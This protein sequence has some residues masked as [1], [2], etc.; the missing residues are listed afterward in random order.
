MPQ[1]KKK[2][3]TKTTKKAVA[4]KVHKKACCRTAC[5]KSKG[6]TTGEKLHLYVVTAL[7]IVA[8]VLLCL[9][10]AMMIAA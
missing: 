1:V 3:A 10:A 6:L 2:K 5:K 4:T 8:G 7:A 9:D